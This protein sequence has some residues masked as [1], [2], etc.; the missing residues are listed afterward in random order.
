MK[1]LIARLRSR[2]LAIRLLVGLTAYA[3]LSTLV[4]LE[5]VSPETARAWDAAHPALA[6]VVGALGL[7]RAYSSPLFVIAAVL[8]TLST[9]ACAWERS[10]R[11]LR[12]WRRYGRSTPG[13]AAG[14]EAAPDFAVATSGRAQS[15]ELAVAALRTAGLRA[16]GRDGIVSGT[17]NRAALLG[18]PLFHWALVGLFAFA[19]L[20]QLVRYEGN[21]NLVMGR[22]KADAAASYDVSLSR[23][24]GVS[25]PFTGASLTV[26][27]IDLKYVADGVDR[28]PTPHVVVAR[29]GAAVA[30][31]WVYPNHPLRAAGLIIH[32]VKAGPALVGTARIGSTGQSETT[33]RYFE[34][35]QTTPDRFGIVDPS[36]GATVT[37]ELKAVTG[38]R[39]AVTALDSS[40]VVTTSAI[41]PAGQPVEVA[42]GVTF[43]VDRLTGYAQLKIVRDPT[44]VWVFAMFTLGVLGIA[45]TVFVPPRRA[46]AVISEDGLRVSVRVARTPIDPDFATRVRDAFGAEDGAAPHDE[47]DGR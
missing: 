16:H 15:T 31:G 13:E 2:R 38:K 3:W 43:T 42:K 36:T 22:P 44:M 26:E 47:G 5:S 40:G 1:R 24:A 39:V 33:V 20:G 7:H 29:D 27:D 19:G 30:S 12:L 28:G 37:L 21:A 23:R 18:S 6:G 11:A 46:V 41:A 4:P 35:G 8:L 45:L 17:R 14:V 34:A 32:R 10:R 25:L 9:G